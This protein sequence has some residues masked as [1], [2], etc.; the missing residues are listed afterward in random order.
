MQTFLEKFAQGILEI[1]AR[2]NLG[3]STKLSKNFKNF[4]NYSPGDLI[5]TFQ[6]FFPRISSRMTSTAPKENNE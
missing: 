6:E 5:T 1:F 4:S 3:D 2:V